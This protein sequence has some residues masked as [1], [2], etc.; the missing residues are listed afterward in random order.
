MLRHRPDEFGLD[1]D[2]YGYAPLEQI[3]EAVQERYEEV[4]EEE[5]VDLLRAPDQRRFELNDRG[6]RALYGHS[7]FVEM[8]GEPMEVPEHLYMGSTPGAA[9]RYASEG[10]SPGDRSYVHLSLDRE[11]AAERSRAEGGPVVVEILARKAQESGVEFYLRG[12]VVLTRQ[13]PAAFVGVVHGASPQPEAIGKPDA[14]PGAATPARP[15]PPGGA[16]VTYGRRPR[17]A[18]R[19]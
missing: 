6:V 8:D 12:P 1:I 17:K 5:V 16:T 19:R 15:V 10:I 18:T 9:R 14:G 2:E 11:T 4:S 7:F 13:V 3:V